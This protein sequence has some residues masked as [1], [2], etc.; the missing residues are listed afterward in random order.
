M[1]RRVVKT[2]S[3]SYMVVLPKEW[4]RSLEVR[5]GRIPEEVDLQIV[6]DEVRILPIIRMH[7][8]V[9]I[10]TVTYPEGGIWPS[11]QS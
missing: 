5:Y 7:G 3:G 4:V 8:T 6:G 2:K 10:G 11:S 9:Q 1:V